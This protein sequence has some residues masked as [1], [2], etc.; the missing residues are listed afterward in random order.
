MQ[1]Y[2]MRHGQ[3]EHYADCDE[4]RPLTKHGQAQVAAMSNH[5]LLGKVF[6]RV[7]VSPFLRAQQTWEIVTK[8]GVKYKSAQT[9]DWITPESSVSIALDNL[10]SE[11][12][13]AKRIL[14]ICHQPFVGKFTTYLCDGNEHGLSVATA[15]ITVSETE[16]LAKQCGELQGAYGPSVL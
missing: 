4:N 10:L 3:A 2:C 16:V 9:V 14:L 5:F 8:Q 12:G 6:E 13:Q 15:G 1:V 7:F 11:V